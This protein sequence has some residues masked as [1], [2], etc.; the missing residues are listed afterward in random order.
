M[1]ESMKYFLEQFQ[2]EEADIRRYSPLTLAYIGDAV[3]EMIVR[4]VLVM[5]GDRPVQEFH[6]QASQ[7]SRAGRQAQ[8]ADAV[9]PILTQEEADILRRGR[10]AHPNTRAKHA[11]M[12][13]YRKAT[14][15]EALMGY[16]YLRHQWN[17]LTDLIKLGMSAGEEM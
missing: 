3:Y 17:R 16:L 8:M 12:A 1:D 7:L 15:L 13:E 11:T 2:L 14:G 9:L 5:R 10:N 4:S 6:R